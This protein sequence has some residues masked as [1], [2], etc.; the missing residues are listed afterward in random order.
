MTDHES[1]SLY[2]PYGLYMADLLENGTSSDVQVKAFDTTYKLHSLLLMRSP[3][4]KCLLEWSRLKK[5]KSLLNNSVDDDDD[6]DDDDR[7]R[8][9]AL[10]N[11]SSVLDLEADVQLVVN[12]QVDDPL[13]TKESFEL[14][15]KRLYA[16]H[17][18]E[19]E[20]EIP[21]QMIATGFYFE[22]EDI[23]E[24]MVKYWTGDAVTMSFVITALQLVSGHDFGKYG[25]HL[26]QR[27]KGYLC[28]NGW[29]AG[30]EAWD[31]IQPSLIPEIVN[32]DDFFVPNEFERIMFAI[33]LLQLSRAN[34][35]E[36]ELAITEF[37]QV[38][39][40]FTLTYAQQRELLNQKLSNDKLIFDL[41]SLNN[42]NILMAH[43]QYHSKLDRIS[44]IPNESLQLPNSPELRQY[45]YIK[46]EGSL[47]DVT[48][49]TTSTMIS[50]FRLSIVLMPEH[51]KEFSNNGS[52]HREFAY[53]GSSWRISLCNYSQSDKTFSLCV[54][55]LPNSY[56]I[57]EPP[58]KKSKLSSKELPF[59]TQALELRDDDPKF[60][61]SNQFSI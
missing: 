10:I 7:N 26:R 51:F 16:I 3:Y 8:D 32:A 31:G 34:D 35:D 18:C 52:Y 43:I 20:K 28:D 9:I 60:L 48:R 55:R 22:M 61:L 6:D 58:V 56:S 5:K 17:D 2:K 59:F 40:F 24:A 36:I 13:I 49:I 1:E 38:F 54:V 47:P 21:I 37:R 30:C 42:S 46:E 23:K 27:C 15:L 25:T 45:A 4:F 29:Q 44:P 11:E 39:N 53:C 57:S 12:V 19:K 14:M 41:S 50:P 33:K